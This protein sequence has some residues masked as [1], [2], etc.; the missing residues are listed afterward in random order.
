MS[1]ATLTIGGPGKDPS[2]AYTP[3][4]T[5]WA[6]TYADG[7]ATWK[8]AAS[9]IWVTDP[10]ALATADSPVTYYTKEI[11]VIGAMLNGGTTY[12]P[13]SGDSQI[14]FQWEWF[15]S[16]GTSM[17]GDLGTPK[18][19]SGGTW[20]A[21][22]GLSH[23]AKT[24]TYGTLTTSAN[25]AVMQNGSKMRVKIVITDAGGNDVSAGLVTNAYNAL[26]HVSAGASISLWM[27]KSAEL[28]AG[29]TIGG[30]GADPS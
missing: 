14:K 27:D 1:Q 15:S 29:V 2:G 9:K 7:A 16:Q 18:S 12:V 10:G 13:A 23:T 17:A 22:G 26:N 24:V 4:D 20:T 25:Y 3:I 28:N 8:P 5:G 19:Q 6:V 21:L 11:T 30:M